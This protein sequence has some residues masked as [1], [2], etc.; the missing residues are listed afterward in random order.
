MILVKNTFIR[1]IQTRDLFIRN[2]F[3]I[4]NIQTIYI[5]RRSVPNAFA[6]LENKNRHPSLR[7]SILFNLKLSDTGEIEKLLHLFSIFVV[8]LYR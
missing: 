5:E 3:Y 1:N 7:T 4:R 6:S 8:F 2:T